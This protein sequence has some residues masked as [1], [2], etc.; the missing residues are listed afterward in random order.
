MALVSYAIRASIW[1]GLLGLFLCRYLMK[2]ARSECSLV[3]RNFCAETELRCSAFLFTLYYYHTYLPI[4]GAYDTLLRL[5][6]LPSF[7]TLPVLRNCT[8]DGYGGAGSV[9]RRTSC[10]GVRSLS[11]RG[12]SKQGRK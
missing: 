8:E 6:L 12:P 4:M 7:A 2:R 5:L 11:L 1:Y 9:G 10:G 3:S